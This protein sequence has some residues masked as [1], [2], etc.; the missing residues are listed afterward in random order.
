MNRD[1]SRGKLIRCPTTNHPTYI[2]ALIERVIDIQRARARYVLYI[3][4]YVSRARAMMFSMYIQGIGACAYARTPPHAPG[5][6]PAWAGDPLVWALDSQVW[7]GDPQFG[8]GTPWFGPG[9]GLGWGPGPESA[10]KIGQKKVILQ[11]KRAHVKDGG[12]SSY[13]KLRLVMNYLLYS[14]D[15]SETSSR[16][17][18]CAILAKIRKIRNFGPLRN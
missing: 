5:P 12:K 1:L 6:P 11:G 2:S 13:Q 14:T 7:A 16:A 3:Y 18:F 17:H 4:G 10:L 8:P 9:T 15:N